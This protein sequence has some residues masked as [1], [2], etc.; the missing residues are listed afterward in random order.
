MR[1]PQPKR[2]L[3]ETVELIVRELGTK[4]VAI[5]K[6]V[7]SALKNLCALDPA[8]PTIGNRKANE[9]YY[10]KVR[11]WVEDGDKL[12]SSLPDN[13]DPMLLFGPETGPLHSEKQ[14]EAMAQVA[15]ENH[16]TLMTTLAALHERCS[17]VIR[18]HIGERGGIGFRQNRAAG[19]ARD[20]CRLTGHPLAWS[21][22][23]S[24]YRKVATDFYEAM[25]GQ[26]GDDMAGY[27]MQRACRRMADADR[28]T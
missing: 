7:T 17:L 18:Q 23:T 3:E 19:A 24:V 28:K 27:E 26:F 12:F 14:I 8:H 25:T 2:T 1:A 9:G 22:P 4:D 15:L 5:R 21:S 20:L 6:R 16:Q 13:V 10:R 11:K